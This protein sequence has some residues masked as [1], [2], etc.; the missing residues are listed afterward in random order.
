MNKLLIID[1]ERCFEIEVKD[2]HLLHFIGGEDRKCGVWVF[3][4][5]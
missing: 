4:D 2:W 3:E 5:Q 1:T